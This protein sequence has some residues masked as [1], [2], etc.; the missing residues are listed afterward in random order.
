MEEYINIGKINMEKYAGLSENKIIT[1]EVIITFKQIEH[2][3][4]ERYGI[5]ER[6]K[7][8]LEEILLNPDY[9]IKDKKHENTG[10]VI[11]QYEKDV[12]VVLRLNLTDN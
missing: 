12:V 11:K 10:L 2:I 8:N 7:D 6:Y 3:D 9:I 4:E 5:F 1:N